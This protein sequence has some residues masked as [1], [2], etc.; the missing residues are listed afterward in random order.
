L[1]TGVGSLG[2]LALRRRGFRPLVH[3]QE[4]SRG[5]VRCS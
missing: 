1:L 4:T 5:M 2:I 3:D